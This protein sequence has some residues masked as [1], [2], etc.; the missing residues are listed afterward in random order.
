V[1]IKEVFL[2]YVRAAYEEYLCFSRWLP[3]IFCC[4]TVSQ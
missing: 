3:N 1:Q 4:K 2:D